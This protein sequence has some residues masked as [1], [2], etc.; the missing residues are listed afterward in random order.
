MHRSMI[1]LALLLLVPS[2][3]ACAPSPSP[4]TQAASADAV[5][6]SALSLIHI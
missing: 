6:A 3:G 1:Q 5:P 2:I 4:A